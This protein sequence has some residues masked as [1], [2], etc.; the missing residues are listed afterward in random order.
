MGG[1][2]NLE[3]NLL[4]IEE[5]IRGERDQP[6]VCFCLGGSGDLS[7]TSI[8][9]WLI[10]LSSTLKYS[11]PIFSN[12]ENELYDHYILIS[13]IFSNGGIKYRHQ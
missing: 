5:S 12:N 13:D 11:N 4:V 7:H 8:L 2:D 9:Y 1:I 6:L 3:E 10:P